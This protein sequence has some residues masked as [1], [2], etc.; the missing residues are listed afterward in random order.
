MRKLVPI[1]LFAFICNSCGRMKDTSAYEERS[2]AFMQSLMK[3]D[4]DQCLHFFALEHEMARGSNLD[5]MKADFAHFRLLLAVNFGEDLEYRLVKKVKTKTPGKNTPLNSTKAYIEF[6][7]DEEFG[8]LTVLFDNSSEKMLAVNAIDIKKPI[9]PMAPFWIF[10]FLALLVPTLNLYI[11]YWIWHSE[12]KNKWPKYLT[13][14]FL[15]IPAI[16]YTAMGGMDFNPTSLQLVWAFG[17]PLGAMYWSWKLYQLERLKES[18]SK[19]RTRRQ[20]RTGKQKRTPA[21]N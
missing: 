3:K 1:L 5:T 4:Y 12:L 9:P 15:N 17:I 18:S 21:Y 8:L 13:V 20:I 10:G 19:S 2:I 11:V 14:L 16:S 6:N 7:N